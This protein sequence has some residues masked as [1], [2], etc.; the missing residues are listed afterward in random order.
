MLKHMCHTHPSEVIAVIL[1]TVLEA[2]MGWLGHPRGL[3]D[4]EDLRQQHPTSLWHTMGQELT[5]NGPLGREQH[6]LSPGK[7][8]ARRGVG[9]HQGVTASPRSCHSLLA[10]RSYRELPVSSRFDHHRQQWQY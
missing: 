5:E 6:P 4:R 10:L 7:L 8:R 1:T 3:K 2:K 9:Y